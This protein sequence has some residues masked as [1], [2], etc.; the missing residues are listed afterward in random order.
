MVVEVCYGTRIRRI[1][2][3]GGLRP[4]VSVAARE[5]AQSNNIARTSTRV[6]TSISDCSSIPCN[7]VMYLKHRRIHM[8]IEILL[9]QFLRHT[10]HRISG[11]L[12]GV[13][14]GQKRDNVMGRTMAS[15]TL[16]K[17]S[18]R[19]AITAGLYLSASLR[20]DEP[21]SQGGIYL[22]NGKY[23]TQRAP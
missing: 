14:Q 22:K 16:S 3:L 5:Q 6:L 13:N 21:G 19:V 7:R 11:I 9:Y 10:G 23:S 20:A 12:K 8:G 2:H 17:G 1:S 15:L 4:T 18:F